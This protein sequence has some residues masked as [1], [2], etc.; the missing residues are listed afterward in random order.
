M[1]H[2]VMMRSGVAF[3]P[4]TSLCVPSSGR[5]KE[6]TL[7]VTKKVPSSSKMVS[8]TIF[9]IASVLS[10]DNLQSIT[11]PQAAGY[12]RGDNLLNI[13]RQAAGNAPAR[14]LKF[15]YSSDLYQRDRMLAS[16][17]PSHGIFGS[18]A[19]AYIDEEGGAEKNR[20]L[21][22]ILK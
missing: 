11:P 6:S 22:S 4:N 20:Q 17:F 16:T 19:Q 1:P 7:S 13:S 10:I 8:T 3:P 18:K 2:S 14:D 15:L 5:F 9:N 21:I 12:E